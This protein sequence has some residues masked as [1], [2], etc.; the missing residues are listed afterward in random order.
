MKI[1]CK[2]EK[3]ISF[4]SLVNNTGLEVV[5][6]TFGASFYDLKVKDFKGNIESII[7]T[8]SNVE[9]FYFSDGYYGKSIGRF[10]GRI[11]KAKCIINSQEYILDKNWN[12]VN[13]LHGGKKGI[14]FSNFEYEILEQEDYTDVIFSY[15]EK[16]NL[17]PGDVNY[18]ITYRIFNY[19][20]DIRIIFNAK[21]TKETI[22]NLTNHVYF[23]L[24]GN[25]RR[26]CLEHDL[27]FNCDKYTRLNNELIT[28]S[29]DNVDRVFD[30]REKHPIGKYIYDSCLQNHTSK[31]YDHCFIKEKID[32]ELISI[33]E[34]PISKRRVK[35]YTSYPAIVCYTGCYPKKFD[36]NKEKI[37]IKQYHS[38]CLE[39]QYVPNGINMDDVDQAILKPGEQYNH[40]IH[41]SFELI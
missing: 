19:K 27:Q 37:K 12:N 22:V 26:D 13:S 7:L 23:N 40:F 4:I 41:Y 8:P 30:F 18:A 17:L 1:Q 20:N 10:S 14:S 32:D 28:L 25:L 16:E 38:V 5:L 36:F 24:S 35:V 39:C 21:T 9:D 29:I 3:D 11:D 33:L 2:K 34:E 31:G 6:S 15:L